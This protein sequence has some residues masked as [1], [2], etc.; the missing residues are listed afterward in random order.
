MDARTISAGLSV[1]SQITPEDVAALAQRGFRT[2]LCNRPDG[3]EDGQPAFAEIA[4]AAESLGLTTRY[5]PVIPGQLSDDD[6]AAFGKALD[7]LPGP[8]L[9]YCRS[10]TRSAML[11]ALSRA[12]TKPL[13]DILAATQGAGYDVSALM[14]R[15]AARVAP[16]STPAHG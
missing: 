13:T 11:W 5:L 6:A 3:E 16:A 10:G 2:I 7:D 15:L 9:A 1:S 14:P 8:A 12:R 4:T